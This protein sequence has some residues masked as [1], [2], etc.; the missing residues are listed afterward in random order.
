MK[1]LSLCEIIVLQHQSALINPI[2]RGP[3]LG[4]GPSS[5]P[6]IGHFRNGYVREMSDHLKLMYLPIEQVFLSLI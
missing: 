4:S 5:G 1:C 2:A 6:D 3:V